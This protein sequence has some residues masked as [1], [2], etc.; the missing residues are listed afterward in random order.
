[1]EVAKT[2]D[3]VPKLMT[4]FLPLFLGWFLGGQETGMEEEPWPY[5]GYPLSYDPITAHAAVGN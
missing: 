2:V 5:V 1:M 3:V 4:L